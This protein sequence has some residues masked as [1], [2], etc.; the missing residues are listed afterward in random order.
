MSVDRRWRALLWAAALLALVYVGGISAVYF[1]PQSSAVATWWPAAGIAVALIVLSPRSWWPSLIVGVVVSSGLANLSA[2]RSLELS[3][4]FGI[5]NAAEALVA[6][7]YLRRRREG[8]PRLESPDDF[9]RLLVA[10]VLGAITVGL[11]IGAA[12]GITGGEALDAMRTVTPSHLASTL[13]IVPLALVWREWHASVHVEL[14][15][16]SV[17]LVGC[18]LLVF[19]PE[20]ALALAFLPLPLLVWAGLRFGTPVVAGQLL[21]VGV[22]TTFL[23]ADG[24]GPFAIGVRSEAIDAGVAGALVQTYLVCAALMSLPLSLAI[25][26]RTQL[27]SR[28]TTER[29]LTNITLDTT[30]TIIIVADL[31]GTV[32]RANPATFRLTG[33]LEDDIVGHPL[34]EGFTLPEREQV[35]RQMFEGGDGA[36]IP[37]SRETDITTAGGERL[38]V[39]WNN[40]LVRDAD[41]TPLYAVMTGVDVTGERTTSGMIRHLLESAIAT[42]LVGLDDQGR[43][44]LFSKGAQQI[45]GREPDEVMGR[46]ISEFI[47]P[48]QLEQWTRRQGAD[49]AFEALVKDVDRGGAPQTRDWTWLRANGTPV[50]VSTTISVVENIVGKKVGYLCVGRDVTDQR[51]SQEMLVAALE[52]ERQGVERLRQLDA[53][54]NEFVSTVSHELRTPTTSIVGYTEMLRDGSAGDPS[55]EQLP[56]LDAI[57][58]NGERLIG[59][60]SDLLTLAGL[61]S[62]SA[63]WERGAVDL[64]QLVAHSEGEMRPMLAN[65]R[66]TVEFRVPREEVTVIGDAG[67]LDRVLM[68]LLSNAVKFTEDGGTITCT[69]ETED[70]EARLT[71]TD[72]G[73]GIPE[74]EQ[75]DLFSKFFRSSTAQDRAI[76]GT[77]LGLSIISSI[78]AAHG[79]RIDVRSAHLEGTTFTVRLPLMR[80]PS[81]PE[82]TSG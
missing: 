63:I 36:G 68:N 34:W 14:A 22:L 78:V 25:A 42:A 35:V 1:A 29:E 5:A 60:A 30:H 32:V 19:W 64:T 28:L 59:I 54:K 23:T 9:L 67:H 16:Q 71:V 80:H 69:L 24:G 6:A 4:L 77:G 15:V 52:K 70:D 79:G 40:D 26:Q 10:C 55:P 3:A 8:R 48:D 13:V 44:T 76:Q 17:L 82:F 53:A 73:I 75:G 74:A 65:R 11:G 72:T 43:I 61:E 37:G 27:L 56:L 57:A 66:L 62:G 2:G 81:R 38:R 31:D 7:A 45:L 41:G 20:Q 58:R 47:D 49:S 50:A 46:N 21:V 12:V 39:V 51:R 18:T 33:F